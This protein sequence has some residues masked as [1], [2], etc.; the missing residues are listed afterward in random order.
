ML[1]HTDTTG[2]SNEGFIRGLQKAILEAD[3]CG[4]QEV[5]FIV[6]SIKHLKGGVYEA[7]LGKDVVEAFAKDKFM[8]MNSVSIYLETDR[9]KS[10]CR[11]GVVFAPFVTDEDISQAAADPRAIDVVY[12]PWAEIEFSAYLA[13]NPSSIQI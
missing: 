13:K 6:P 5:I 10:P 1:Y 7:V 2:P 8:K 4:L 12:V 9:I 3:K 11:R